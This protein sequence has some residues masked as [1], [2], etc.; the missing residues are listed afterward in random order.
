[1]GVPCVNR[2]YVTIPSSGTLTVTKSCVT[3]TS[4]S[5]A[6][7]GVLLNAKDLMQL[8]SNGEYGFRQDLTVGNVRLANDSCFFYFTNAPCRPLVFILLP[9]PPMPIKRLLLCMLRFTF[10]PTVAVRLRKWTFRFRAA[11]RNRHPHHRRNRRP[12]HH[13]FRPHH[14]QQ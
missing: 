10:R 7:D 2:S 4:T 14:C 12:H 13:H 3:P 11:E 9:S 1:M 6:T 8:M 5:C